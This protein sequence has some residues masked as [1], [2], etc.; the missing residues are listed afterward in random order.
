MGLSADGQAAAVGLRNGTVLLIEPGGPTSTRRLAAHTQYPIQ[1]VAVT[2]AAILTIQPEKRSRRPLVHVFNR[3]SLKLACVIPSAPDVAALASSGTVAIAAPGQIE[4]WTAPYRTPRT[5]AVAADGPPRGLGVS[6]DGK[7]VACL[8]AAEVVVLD[9]NLGTIVWRVATPPAKGKAVVDS[10][11]WDDRA[12][13]FR[14][15]ALPLRRHPNSQSWVRPL[16]HGRLITVDGAKDAGTSEVVIE[17][18]DAATQRRLAHEV[19]TM[20][21]DAGHAG[22]ASQIGIGNDVVVINAQRYLRIT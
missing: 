11:E 19:I 17:L 9:A 6:D 4:L 16:P 1:A 12:Q 7:L 22:L 14:T 5:V 21:A 2:D 3:A 15:V 20:S 10:L 8:F 13:E 18:W